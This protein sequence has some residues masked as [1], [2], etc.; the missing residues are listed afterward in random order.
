[1]TKKFKTEK[2][3][4]EAS[5]KAS[6]RI[7]LAGEVH[8]VAESL[9]KPVMTDVVS[10]VLDETPVEKIKSVSLS[11]NTV[12]RRIEDI[13]SNM[14][15]QLVS[16]LRDCDTGFAILLVFVWY[17]FNKGI[18]QDSLLCKSLELHNTGNNIF[19]VIDDYIKAQ[20][21]DWEKC[22][23]VCS[24]GAK[25]MTG[26]LNGAV[27]RIKNASKNC[28]SVHCIIHRYALVTKNMS[29]PLKKVLDEA[30]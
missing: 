27:T 5:Y 19:N 15:K 18:E 25:A 7:A 11:S 26:K 2:N 16:R 23:S 29:P 12:S 28:K 8:T 1:M 17:P 20:S 14:E 21:I 22:I 24:D 9:I 13:A 3:A 6:Y 4:I 10:C 30:V